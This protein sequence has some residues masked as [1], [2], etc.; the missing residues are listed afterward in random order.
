MD[1]FIGQLLLASFGFAPKGWAQCNGQL[2]PIN[3]NQALFALLGTFFGGNGV[4]NFAL[5][6]LQGRTPIGMNSNFPIGVNGGEASHTL[7]QSEAPQHTH[8]LQAATAGANVDSPTGAI[9]AGNGANIFIV[10]GNLKAMASQSLSTV[11]GQPHENRQPY[12]VMNWCIALTGI[13]PSR[14]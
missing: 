3:Q 1:Q 11:G 14:N 2:L 5:P 7:T 12:L 13:F 9:L 4:Q 8:N 6:N 10:S